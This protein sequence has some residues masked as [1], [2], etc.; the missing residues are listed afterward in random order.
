MPT[1]QELEAVYL[2][3]YGQPAQTGWSP[4]RRHRF[5]YYLPA[6]IYEAVVTRHVHPGCNWLDV[7]G[8]HSIFPDNPTL[9]RELVARCSRV[10][11]IDPS[12]NVHRNSFVHD[13]VQCRLEDY[14]SHAQFDLATLRMVV[15]HVDKP[16]EFTDAL[17]RLVRPGGRIV[18]FTVNRWAPISI[19]SHL[20]P[21]RLH[22]PIKRI[23][24][25]SEE[26]DT[27]PVRYLMN[28]RKSL[29]RVFEGAEFSEESFLHLDDLSTF[30]RFRW[31]GYME[32]AAWKAMNTLGFTY[33]EN[34]LLGVYR[35]NGAHFPGTKEDR[36][37]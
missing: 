9:A 13:R 31:I 8:G 21:Y 17:K 35:R 1:N 28:T 34:C 12:D 15:E 6:D 26:G 16:Y 30:G 32:L 10:V 36:L 7:G 25:G 3:K 33:P 22:H 27:F 29:R 23:F 4:R 18:V 11:A 5:C 2:S 20:M 14:A 24:W 37:A 19:I